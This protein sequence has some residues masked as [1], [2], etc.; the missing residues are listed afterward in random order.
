VV[1]LGNAGILRGPK[2]TSTIKAIWAT[3]YYTIPLAIGAR[4]MCP[5]INQC[6]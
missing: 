6:P 2:K 1:Q 3:T 4:L 5:S